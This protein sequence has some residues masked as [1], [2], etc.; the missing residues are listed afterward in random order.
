MVVESPPFLHHDNRG[1]RRATALVS[2][3]GFELAGF[4]RERYVL[5][6]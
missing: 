3:V 6:D 2:H 4:A 1:A 5:C